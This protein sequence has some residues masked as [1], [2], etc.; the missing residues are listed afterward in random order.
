MKLNLDDDGVAY[1]TIQCLYDTNEE[2]AGLDVGRTYKDTET[3]TDES[4]DWVESTDTDSFTWVL[5]MGVYHPYVPHAEIGK[6]LGTDI[7]ISEREESQLRRKTLEEPDEIIDDE[8]RAL[9]ELYDA[10]I[11]YTDQQIGRLIE[12][13][14]A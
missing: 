13:A 5:Y 6:Q 11:R 3:I 2:K 4:I 1:R 8:L 12:T 7:A 9:T 14:N 10:E